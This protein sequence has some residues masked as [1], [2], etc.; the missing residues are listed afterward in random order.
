MSRY[1]EFKD[2]ESSKFCEITVAGKKVTIHYGK[3][4]MAGQNTVKQLTTPAEANANG[5]TF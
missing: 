5:A 3:I 4:G 1:F 2:K